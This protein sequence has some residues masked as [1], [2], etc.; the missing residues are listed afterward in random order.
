MMHP[1]TN[2]APGQE[3][4]IPAGKTES[5]TASAIDPRSRPSWC[6]LLRISL[7]AFPVKAFP[8]VSSTSASQFHLLR[9][10]CGQRIQY[11]KTC[12]E[13]GAVQADAIV[14]GYEYARGQYVVVN[15]EELEQ[16]RPPRDKALVLEQF[17]PVAE[18]DPVLYARP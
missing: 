6:G 15:P 4:A 2:P 8:A 18:I 5:R 3:H 10:G 12:S 17:V 16:L 13:H 9:A 7:V 11:L 1:A 14:K